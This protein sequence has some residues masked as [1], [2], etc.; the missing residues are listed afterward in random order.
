MCEISFHDIINRAIHY[1]Y[2]MTSSYTKIPKHGQMSM[3]WTL[4]FQFNSLIQICDKKNLT[5]WKMF[6]KPAK[7]SL[8]NI[9]Q[10]S[11]NKILSQQLT[12]ERFY[13]S[14]L[15][16]NHTIQ[17]FNNLRKEAFENILGK[18]ENAG[19]HHFLL[20]PKWFLFFQ[21]QFHFLH[22]IYFVVCKSFE[23]GPV[24]NCVVC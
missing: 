16:L 13:M 4:I 11:F 24:Q 22:R 8:N 10:D 3:F 7:N 19:N 23:F 21:R 20:S 14:C 15:N 6:F 18:G 2:I 17:T 12:H 9:F 1:I 5:S